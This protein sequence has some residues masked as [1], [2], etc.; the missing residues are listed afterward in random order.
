MPAEH[1][2]FV[3]EK[4]SITIDGI[5]LTVN[6]V[7]GSLFTVN[8]IP[9]TAS[10]TTLPGRRPGDEV[11]IETDILAKYVARLM[12]SG[13]GEIREGGLSFETLARNGFL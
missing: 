8:V 10:V 5:S 4:G 7:T 12:N 11:N 9:H 2:R 6:T 1:A 13:Q 3:V